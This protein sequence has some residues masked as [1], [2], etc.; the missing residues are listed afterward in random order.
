M[1]KRK[2]E[3]PLPADLKKALARIDRRVSTVQNLL[4]DIDQKLCHII[5][6]LREA[7]DRQRN[8]GD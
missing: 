3:R 2:D 1:A 4:T 7:R 5:R 8:N 6:Q